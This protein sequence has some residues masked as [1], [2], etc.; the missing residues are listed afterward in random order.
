MIENS[1]DNTLEIH[2][3][4]NDWH[5]SSGPT[6][7]GYA[8]KMLS[9][10]LEHEGC[11][12]EEIASFLPEFEKAL[13]SAETMYP[14]VIITPLV[15]KEWIGVKLRNKARTWEDNIDQKRTG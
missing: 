10:K 2:I 11:T 12:E 5:I 13:K 1:Q 9:R 3:E 8:K 15:D 6:S 7:V 14:E 4:D